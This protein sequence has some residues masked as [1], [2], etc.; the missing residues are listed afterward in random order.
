MATACNSLPVLMQLDRYDGVC[1]EEETQ[2]HT[3]MN[4]HTTIYLRC[5]V[6]AKIIGPRGIRLGEQVQWAFTERLGNQALTTG[7]GI[8]SSKKGQIN[9][10]LGAMGS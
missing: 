1:G 2:L 10:D 3:P 5:I 7:L 6:S 9:V 4:L 8:E